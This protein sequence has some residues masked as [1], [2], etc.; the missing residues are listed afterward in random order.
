MAVTVWVA[1]RGGWTEPATAEL[2][3]RFCARAA[4][5]LGDQRPRQQDADH[6]AA[7]TT[8]VFTH[9]MG[10]RPRRRTRRESPTSRG[11]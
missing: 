9:T 2:F 11:A 7:P 4:A 6:Q 5:R 3:G 8:A 10:G 1:A